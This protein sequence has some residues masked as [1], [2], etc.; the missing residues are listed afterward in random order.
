MKAY[1]ARDK[2]GMLYLYMT[3]PNKLILAWSVS[4]GDSY[5][6]INE[7]DDRYAHI[8]WEDDEPTEVTL[9]IKL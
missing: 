8:K 6:R 1:L 4:L 7:T 3:K 9:E 5:N 2:D